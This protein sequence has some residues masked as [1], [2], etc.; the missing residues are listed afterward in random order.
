MKR[1]VVASALSCALIGVA[2]PGAAQRPAPSAPSPPT[3]TASWSLRVAMNERAAASAIE[4]TDAQSG[5]IHFAARFPSARPA[6]EIT[7][8]YHGGLVS[9]AFDCRAATFST[10]ATRTYGPQGA[11]LSD[12]PG[13]RVDRP[14]A[15][16]PSEV[17][18]LVEAACAGKPLPALGTMSGTAAE[19]M[20]ALGRMVGPPPAAAAPGAAISRGEWS[21]S[22]ASHNVAIGWSA[23]PLGERSGLLHVARAYAVEVRT[24]MGAPAHFG[25]VASYRYDCAWNA[26]TLIAR[27]LYDED[28]IELGRLD[29]GAARVQPFQSAGQLAPLFRAACGDADRRARDRAT[30]DA[31]GVQRW[32][33]E[34]ADR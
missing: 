9:H 6:T 33:T 27:R 29:G 13:S 22:E 23:R 24:V 31:T 32:L 25:E 19:V 21:L 11:Q 17:R 30:H 26:Q 7:P 18:E 15:D 16:L 4:R 1:I 14:F 12:V 28:G 5:T 34:H 3:P 10:L 2:A 8:P 20:N